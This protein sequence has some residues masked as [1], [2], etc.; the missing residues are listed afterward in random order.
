MTNIFLEINWY[1]FR[2]NTQVDCAS[3]YQSVVMIEEKKKKKKIVG[4]CR[5]CFFEFFCLESEENQE[6]NHQTEETHSF[7][8][9]KTKNGVGEKLL[10]Q[11][12]VSGITNDKRTEHSSNTSTRSS[13]SYGSGTGT[14]KFGSGIDV[15]TNWSSSDISSQA[16]AKSWRT[17]KLTGSHFIYYRLSVL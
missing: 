14:N 5:Y 1:F 7:G 12:W 16:H 8:Q 4:C 10:F 11:G 2:L 13:D 15:L 6:S 17:D 3:F 9:S